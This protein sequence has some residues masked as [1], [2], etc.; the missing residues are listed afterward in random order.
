MND[1]QIALDFGGA[2]APDPLTVRDEEARRQA[3]DPGVNIALEASA[4]TGKTRVLV[5][6]YINLLRAGVDPRNILAIT[7]TR[8]AA[9]E[10]RQRI[11]DRLRE[12]AVQG[13]IP[14]ERWQD[15]RDRLGEIAISTIDAFC[16]SLL[17]EFPL[18]ADV[19][20]GFTMVDET[21][22][23]GL[24]DEALDRALRIGRARSVE[25]E[26]V[27]LV[28]T[29]LGEH[30]LRRGLARLL[31][32]RLVAER[33]LDRYLARGPRAL[34]AVEAAR[35][36]AVRLLRAFDEAPGGLDG[37]L[38]SGPLDDPRFSLLAHDLRR[39][40]A[41]PAEP[42]DA[43]DDGR[44]QALMARCREYFFTAKGE[45]RKR[46]AQTAAQFASRTAY[47]THGAQVAGLAPSIAQAMAAHRR[48]LNVILSRGVRWLFA[49]ALEEYRRTLDDHA[50]LDFSDVLARALALLRQMD[51]FS[52][53]RYRL[54]SRYQH[55]LVDEFQDTSRAQWE[56]V[57]LLIRSWGEGL[58]LAGEGR[59][60]PSVFIVGDRKQSIYG[61]RDADV[62]VLDEAARF[63]GA[64]RP[65][66][67]VRRAIARSFR[68][69]PPLLAFVNDLFGAV[70]KTPSRPDAFRYDEQDR[71]PLMS[72]AGADEEGLGVVA[73]RDV[74]S[75]ARAVAAEI[76]ALM[77]GGV[78]VRDRDSGL[79]RPLQAGDVAILFRSRDTHRE[80]ERELERANLPYYV[81][82]GLGF[83]DADEIKDVL[84]L[85]QYL[86]DPHSDLRA[87]A[88]LRS[89]FVRLSDAG[90]KL[91][92][93]RLAA[94]FQDEA[95][96]AAMSRLSEEDRAVL[97]LARPALRGWCE[98][99]DRV[100]PA[101]LLD[102]VLTESAYAVEVSGR[103]LIQ[104][105][106][107]LKK[108]RA[109]VRRIQ[110]RGYATLARVADHCSQLAA[111][112]ESNAVIDAVDAVN[113]MTVHAAKGLEFPVVFI[114]NLTRGAGG[115]DDA[116][117][118]SGTEAETAEGRETGVPSDTVAVG[119]FESDVDRDAAAREREETKRLLY[120]AMTRARD[121]LYLAA[122][123]TSDGELRPGKG[124]LA[125]V[126]P[127]SLH[128]VFV[129]AGTAAAGDLVTWTGPSH[130]HR[131]RACQP[132]TVVRPLPAEAWPEAR[133]DDFGSVQ[134]YAPGPRRTVT[135]VDSWD[136]DA[137]AGRPTGA[138][139]LA[140]GGA[141]VHRA[142]Q[143]LV[144]FTLA[145]A[146]LELRAA[147]AALVRESERREGEHLGRAIAEAAE[148]FASLAGQ[149][150]LRR[151]LASG[152]TIHELPFV[153]AIDG[154][155]QLRGVIDCLVVS[156]EGTV[157]VL[158]FKTGAPQH[159]HRRQLEAYIEAAKVLFPGLSVEGRL[160]YSR[161]L[162]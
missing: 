156:P 15:L 88:L 72:G 23:P 64:L 71:F 46:P 160:V 27:A 99:T 91:L 38:D 154:G 53:S 95:P 78:L 115:G 149:D 58:G 140:L 94:A 69:R 90:V 135:G 151:L 120:V 66:A 82:K 89:R 103:G 37:F 61:F 86:A 157:T 127:S 12:Q 68:A 162:P 129:A 31:D 62:A 161:W 104:A 45:P 134:P 141:L 159:V 29:H 155:G 43:T 143:S 50:V 126:L 40:R 83:F 142:I 107:N 3:V 20:P 26:D 111:G 158:E 114:V 97:A 9:A 48:D 51:E 34:T 122:T 63:I 93:P 11:V 36:A 79:R 153:M 101:E 21:E 8:K 16:L 39:L 146:P 49:R 59:L 6:R 30:R 133:V 24:V 52:R 100:P 108:L 77:D 105:R 42:A 119:D 116:I 47:R 2:D 102:R 44:V 80:F 150:D 92:A 85:V 144:P 73:A 10:M 1:R 84:A 112:D 7:F 118:V 19:D 55:V 75:C 152:R 117:R 110:N 14:P 98:M 74:A 76:A 137:P 65:E 106:E 109:L 113:L 136:E 32:R 5:D 28:F 132:S 67:D 81:Y 130:V 56:L 121:R 57:E 33:A 125:D 147:L 41:L 138:E 13:E 18:E 54:E 4:G 96:P 35:R 139:R 25:Q 70:E 60:P 131:F 87:A 128:A 22:M 148:A 124:S 123:L 17:R 145:E